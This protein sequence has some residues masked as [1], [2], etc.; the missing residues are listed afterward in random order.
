[1]LLQEILIFILLI[2]VI[3]EIL[4]VGIFIPFECRKFKLLLLLFFFW[5]HHT[6]CGILVPRPGIEPAP[7]ALEA[8]SL[9]TGPPGKSLNKYIFKSTQ[10]KNGSLNVNS[11]NQN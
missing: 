2:S 1:M 7:P 4:R 9:N 3:Y 11:Q 8:W 5:P 6:A 10:S